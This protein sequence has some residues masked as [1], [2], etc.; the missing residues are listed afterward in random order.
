MPEDKGQQVGQVQAPQSAKDVPQ[1]AA[2]APISPDYARAIGRFAYV[3][4]WPLV[5][6]YNRQKL[7]AMAPHPGLLGGVLPVAPLNQLTMLS[8]YLDPKQRFVTSPNQDVVYGAGFLALDREPVVVQVPDFGNRFWV[9]QI[10]DQRTDSFARLG[11]QYGTRPGF[12]LLAGPHWK[13]ET[14]KGVNAVYRS[15]TNLGA[16]FPRVFMDDTAEDHEA[17]QALVDQVVAYPLSKF[18]GKMQITDWSEAP[19]I[20][21]PSAGGDKE[22]QWVNPEVF[23]DQLPQVMKDVP[24]LPGE[25]GLYASI[26]Q[27][28]DAATKDPVVRTA[29]RECAIETEKNCID[30]VFEFRNNGVDAGNGW[31]TQENAARFG[32]DYFQR[33][34]TAKGNMFSNVPEETKYFGADFDS[35]GERLNGSKS[36]VVTFLKGSLPPVSGFWSLTLYNEQHFFHPNTLGRFS[37]GTKS[38][39]LAKNADGGLTIHVQA[40]NPGGDKESNWLPAPDG[41]FSLYIRAYWP[42]QSIVSDSW[43]PPT[44]NR[45]G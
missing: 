23:F 28:L 13:G 14:P 10:V 3:W 33:T 32:Y 11:K 27:V 37:L 36:Y 17:I 42:D 41:N 22:T 31:R 40:Q 26:K 39:Q 45:R 6:M 34:A 21:N 38:R 9:Y 25:E 44:I 19:T 18:S 30:D 4:G 1:P 29:L 16:V 43:L 20:D 8:A 2:G 35:K 5:N 24:P 12:Y 15:S 7:F